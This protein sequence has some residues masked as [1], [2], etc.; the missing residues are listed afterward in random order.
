[1][2]SKILNFP[3]F[4]DRRGTLLPIEFQDLP[5]PVE[6]VFFISDSPE[7]LERG[8]HFAGCRELCILVSGQASFTLGYP[9][10][11]GIKV[12]LQNPGDA[13]LIDS[14][15]YV[16]YSLQDQDSKILVIAEKPYAETIKGRKMRRSSNSGSSREGH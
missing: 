16:R 2:K 11:E 7:G 5:F 14:G 12:K 15:D 6:R 8:G 4:S 10:A 1:M 3:I 9:E 13:V